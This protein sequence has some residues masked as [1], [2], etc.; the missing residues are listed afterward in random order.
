MKRECGRSAIGTG[1]RRLRGPIGELSF[2]LAAVAIAW[3]FPVRAFAQAPSQE[4]QTATSPITPAV[5]S[6][7]GQ[8]STLTGDW[9]GLRTILSNEG[10]DIKSGFRDEAVTNLLGGQ[11]A[12]AAQAGQFD[13]G[14]AIDMQKLFGWTGGKLQ[15]TMTYRE[16]ALLPVNLLQQP[17]EIFGR[18]DI[19]RLVELSYEQKLFDDHLTVKF[20]RLPEGEFNDFG[21]DFANLT[22]CGPPAG[23]IVGNY[24]FNA[25][26]AQWAAWGRIDVGNFDFRTGVYETNPRDL[27]LSFSPGWFCCATGVTVHGEVGWSPNFGPNALQGHYQAGFWYDTAGGPDVLLDATGRPFVLTGL[28]PL[29]TSGRYGFYVQGIQQITGTGAYNPEGDYQPRKQ[30][31]WTTTKGLAVFFNF[32]QTDRATATLDN[33]IAA[34][35]LYAAPFESRPHDMIGVAIGRTGYNS[36]A[37]EAIELANP[38][39]AVPRAEYPLE[40]FYK[41]QVRPGWDMQ[42]DFQ[43]VVQ[44]GGYVHVP[45]VV[46]LGIRTNLE[47]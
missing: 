34:G 21:C 20:G 30:N 15:A 12:S 32:I 26:I 25:P 36:H 17:Q 42:P 41:F 28:P 13:L 4:G 40:L 22:F 31:G 33:Q 8:P 14:V 1:R 47:F 23:N 38:G 3:S 29:Q 39:V 43:Y 37:A 16:G 6:S 11:P 44:P 19:A 5:A 10:I 27:D 45:P 2:A 7:G 35:L 9:G 46:I 18:G 24:W